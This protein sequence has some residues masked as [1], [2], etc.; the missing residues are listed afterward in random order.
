M[1][2]YDELVRKIEFIDSELADQSNEVFKLRKTVDF[3]LSHE[4]NEIVLFWNGVA[5]QG[6]KYIFEGEYQ[7]VVF[8]PISFGEELVAVEDVNLHI[9][10]LHTEEVQKNGKII[11]KTY[12]L[13]KL[14]RQ[15]ANITDFIGK[16]NEQKCK[17]KQKGECKND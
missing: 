10:I 1:S 13:D 7:E 8:T 17:C 6:V 4:K 16:E 2:K 15:V 12:H 11:K 5:N 9:S 14:M 3:L